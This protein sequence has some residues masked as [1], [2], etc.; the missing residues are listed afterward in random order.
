M[1]AVSFFVVVCGVAV[2]AAQADMAC[3][4]PTNF[5][6]TFNSSCTD[7]GDEGCWLPSMPGAGDTAKV[8]AGT[9]ATLHA[10]LG[11]FSLLN[12]G[13]LVIEAGA[14]VTM[15]GNAIQI[16]E[17]LIVLGGLNLISRPYGQNHTIPTSNVPY[18]ADPSQPENTDCKLIPI[19]FT[20]R[21]CGPGEL[22]ARAGGAVHLGE[23]YSSLFITT[24]IS[25]GASLLAED[26]SF[27]WGRTTNN[28]TFNS[29]GYIY[30]HGFLY[31][32]G[33]ANI[34]A[35]AFDKW[36]TSFVESPP[37]LFLNHAEIHFWHNL[38]TT[39]ANYTATNGG[40]GVYKAVLE[41]YQ[42]AFFHIPFDV[43]LIAGTEFDIFNFNTITWEG[44][45]SVWGTGWNGNGDYV[46]RGEFVAK[47][48]LV[49]F[50]TYHSVGGQL[51]ATNGGQFNFGNGA[52]NPTT[53]K[54]C[55]MQ[56]TELPEIQ[57]KPRQPLRRDLIVP[58]D[59]CWWYG[60]FCYNTPYMWRAP[61]IENIPIAKVIPSHSV[62][63]ELARIIKKMVVPSPCTDRYSFSGKSTLVGD[64]VGSLVT[65]VPISLEGTLTIK[66]GGKWFAMT[67]NG[68]PPVWGGGK[69]KVQR[70]GEMYLGI[71][72]D[73]NHDGTIV[74]EAG[75]RLNVPRHAHV[76]ISNHTI[77]V[78]RGGIFQVDGELT[79]HPLSKPIKQCGE[80]RGNGKVVKSKVEDMQC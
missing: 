24:H 44:E 10:D 58:R 32:Y 62:G 70:T 54:L 2:I 18:A 71:T 75:G 43:T 53:V 7:F 69:I 49:Y 68:N 15:E 51:T 60:E 38:H 73:F 61:S 52:V 14:N 20:P 26:G 17:C 67:E 57:S 16:Q 34:N 29:T 4:M 21:I 56:L 46:N 9:N 11:P 13:T 37:L 74:V 3:P 59:G 63:I 76:E 47:G 40:K 66:E 35:V 8:P 25:Q 27:I 28:G 50:S 5:T 41:N 79:T 33:L 31:N 12:I 6:T 65:T 19:G 42:D 64:G 55:T 1:R 36:A 23:R 48:V 22:H 78:R 39:Q 80:L 72:A 77:D 30:M 45:S